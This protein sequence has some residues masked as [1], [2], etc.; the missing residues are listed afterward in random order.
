M[1]PVNKLRASVAKAFHGPHRVFWLYIATFAVF[2]LKIAGGVGQYWDW[3]FPIFRGQIGNLFARSDMSWTSGQMGSPLGYVSDYFVRLVVSMIRFLQPETLLYGLIVLLFAVSAYGVYKI[4][5]PRTNRWIAVLLGFVALVNPTMF[6]KYTAGH[7]DYFVSYAVF[8]YLI[9]YLFYKFK[10]DLRSAVVVGLFFAFVGAQIQF[11]A[12]TAILLAL[13]FVINRKQWQL[14]YVAVVAG[15]PIAVNL[16]WLANFADRAASVASIS[17]TATKGAFATTSSTDFLN[18]FNFRFSTATLISR[19]FGTHQLLIYTAL[20]SLAV[21][22]FARTW[23]K[24]KDANALLLLGLI[25]V[26]AFLGTG[27]FQRANLGPI[28][29]LYPMFREVGHFAPIMVL[30]IVLMVGWLLPKRM[31][32]LS[33]GFYLASAAVIMLVSLGIAGSKFQAHPQKVDFAG[34]RRQLNEFQQFGNAHPAN[35]Y[36]VLEY[37]F[38]DQYSL[39]AQGAQSP[40]AGLPSSNTGHDSYSAFSNQQFVKTAVKP[41]DFQTSLQYQL[42]ETKNVDILKP[43]NIRYL[44]DFTSVYQ[45]NYDRYVPTLTYNNDL[46]LIK[47]NKDFFNQLLAANP[48]KLKRVSPHILEITHYGS[49]LTADSNLFAFNSVAAAQSALAFVQGLAP[50]GQAYYATDTKPQPNA[51]SVVP[52]FNEGSGNYG[53][54]NQT[55]LSQAVHVNGATSKTTLYASAAPTEISYSTQDGQ[56]TIYADNSGKLYANGVLALDQDT[57]TKQQ[58]L[59]IPMDSSRTYFVQLNSIVT[60]LSPDT[61]ATIG[62]I[63]QGKDVKVFASSSD[64]LVK[65]GSFEDGLWQNKVSDCNNYDNSPDIHM[66]LNTSDAT[67]G[68]KALSLTAARHIACTSTS[69]SVSPSSTYFLRYDYKGINASSASYFIPFNNLNSLNVRGSQTITDANWHTASSIFTSPANA[70]SAQIFVHA[71]PNADITTTATDLYDNFNITQVQQLNDVVLPNPSSYSYNKVDLPTT[72]DTTLSYT[73][74]SDNYQNLITNGSFENGPWQPIVTDCA[75]YDDAANIAMFIDTKSASDGKQSI[76]LSSTHHTACTYATA[77]VTAGQN[78]LISFDYKSV[79]SK[80]FGYKVKFDDESGTVHSAVIPGDLD[81]KWH[82][83]EQ[84]ISVPAGSTG[85]KLYL[86]VQE[87]GNTKTTTVGFDNVSLINLPPLT[88]RF[89][90]V[91]APTTILKTPKQVKFKTNSITRRTISVQGATTPFYV[92]LSESYHS[93]WRLALNGGKAVPGKNHFMLSNYAN[94]WYVDPA[95]LCANNTKACAHNPDG[96]YTFVLTASFTPQ[97]YFDIAIV[98]SIVSIV[99]SVGYVVHAG[100]STYKPWRIHARK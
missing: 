83:F 97:R 1:K 59:Q 79:N 48:G 32:F 20:L 89:F 28:T 14:R 75:N 19:F 24:Q 49:R 78:Y 7:F 56:L 42:L 29:T 98:V 90:L 34:L 23:R 25:V 37:P 17:G 2:F 13:Y 44:Y 40:E 84:T 50:N 45:S 8:I 36:R 100:R 81:G 67:D 16:I 33:D 12:F 85:V 73:S 96:S 41:Q 31:Q 35:N 86:Y 58:L 26:M 54:S 15:L 69:F 66:K 57:Q 46:S 39:Q 62:T 71:D 65:N 95:V 47:N 61:S 53:A 22:L 63:D 27:L 70:K 68:K 64:N 38:F 60:Q 9:Y 76:S 87:P 10:P 55:T 72:G 30:G 43:Y 4:V 21:A 52:A 77:P 5:R 88:Q 93:M 99:G 6:Y 18:V 51:T 91:N 11:F 92:S 3:S 74:P 94:G 82:T 80:Q